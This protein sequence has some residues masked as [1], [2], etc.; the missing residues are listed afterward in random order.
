LLL[1]ASFTRFTPGMGMDDS[2]VIETSEYSLTNRSCIYYEDIK[3]LSLKDLESL[4]RA[5]RL[6]KRTPVSAVLLQRIRDGAMISVDRKEQ[7]KQ[8]VLK[9]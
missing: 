2:C 6:Q 5:G 3:E 7:Y 1:V 9:Q 4:G 8:I